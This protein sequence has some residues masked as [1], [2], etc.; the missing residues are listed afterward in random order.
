M[1]NNK[2]TRSTIITA[3][4]MLALGLLIGWLIKPS[5]GH[6][7]SNNS[8]IQ[9]SNNQIWTCSMDPQVR[10]SEPGK[11]P[12]CGM[13]L[14]PLEEGAADGDPLEVKMSPNAMALANIQTAVV[15]YGSPVREVR[16]NGKVQPDERLKF[17]QVTHLDGRVE[18]LAVNFTGE[19]VRK[20]QRIA[21]VYSPE[22]VTAQQELFSA[23]KI[24]DM[25]PGLFTAAKQKLKNWKLSDQQ[26]E[27]II[28]AGTPQERF[29][30]HAD[31]S[32]IVLEKMVNLG[33]YVM[34]GMPLYQVV[35][36][37]RVW[38]LFDVYESDMAWAKVG[39]MVEF[40]VQ[41]LP[42]EN[43]KGKI[44]F[45]DPVIDPMTR[46][47]KARVEIANPGGK[48]KPEMFATG[49]IQSQL[50]VKKDK[51]IVPKSAVLWTGERSVVYEKRTT[52]AG[53]TFVMR[54]IK[55]GPLTG[56][57]YVVTEGLEPGTEIAVSG[58]FSI[59][60]AAQLAGKP[61]MMNPAGGAVMTGH[62]HGGGSS[63]TAAPAQSM[64]VSK[65]AKS[66]VKQLFDFYFPMKDALVKG[67]L[68]TA[69]KQA[70]DLKNAFDKTSMSLFTGPAHDHWMKHSGAAIA[71]LNKITAAKD[72]ETAR[73]HFKP[74]SALM[75]VL[76]KAFGPFGETVYVQHCPM[77][78]GNTG[79]DWL[80]LDK[81][82]LNPYF[83][84]KMLKCG[85]VTETIK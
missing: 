4:V 44:T 40:T 21:S 54:E 17:S 77:A 1:K 70:A 80:S 73:K 75:V 39:S 6:E 50:A 43:F 27:Q 61:S 78:D 41:S 31:V 79:A 74:F 58:T 65:Q 85:K 12:I 64:E 29:P 48:L 47:A 72:V 52:D 8:T 42:G 81:Q 32:G 63:S 68:A 82:I 33:D 37:S 57:G 66:A 59:D 20:G 14:I 53:V 38:V 9:Q 69:K 11:C 2:I 10:Q 46:V 13:D 19:P 36:L 3:I 62:Q 28:A 30:I 76:A 60:A 15:G 67:D 26:I 55:L 5:H 22:L 83:G 25:Q 45:I 49:V 24:K 35:D 7:A 16:M 23:L 51:L 18:Q 71:E 34:R 56:D 84:D